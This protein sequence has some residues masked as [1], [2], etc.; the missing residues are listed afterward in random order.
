MV[1]V[2]VGSVS[3]AVLVLGLTALVPVSIAMTLVVSALHDDQRPCFWAGF[4]AVRAFGAIL[5]T[6]ELAPVAQVWFTRVM[7]LLGL[8]GFLGVLGG[9][10]QC[11]MQSQE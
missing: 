3:P 9:I 8:E 2:S 5:L 7:I 1:A 11:V 10:V 6:P 4:G